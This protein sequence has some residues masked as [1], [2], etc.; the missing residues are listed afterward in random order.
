MD[1][2]ASRNGVSLTK[3]AS[4]RGPRGGGRAS[5][6]RS[7]EVMLRKSSDTGISLHGG[8]FLAEGNLESGGGGGSYNGDLNEGGLWARDIALRGGSIKGTWRGSSY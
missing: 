6:L 7:L 3:E 8:S 5:S 2:G 4:W 1:E